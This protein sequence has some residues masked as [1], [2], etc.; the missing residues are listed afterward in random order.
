V[1]SKAPAV[2][3]VV[4]TVGLV[5]ALVTAGLSQ[6]VALRLVGL[7]RSTWHYRSKPRPRVTDPVPHT[8]RPS[9]S[10]LSTAEQDTIVAKLRAAFAQGWS[11]YHAYF[12]ALDAGDPV[13]SL[14]SWHRTARSHLSAQR[15]VK[16]TRNHRSCAMPSLVVDAPMQAWSWDIT[17]LKG[18]YR[19]VTYQFYVAIDVFSR[20]IVAWR[21]EAREDDDLARDMFDAAFTSHGA[22]PRIVHSDGG[23]AMTSN[24]LT[25]LFRELGIEVSRN[26]PRVS[27]DNPFSEALFKTAK[28]DPTYPTHFTDIEHARTWATTFVAWYNHDHHHAGLAGHTPAD[29]HHGTWREVH[30]RRVTAMHQLYALHPERFRNPP[31]LKTPM[32]QVA[33]NHPTTDDRLQTG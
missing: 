17:H 12:E 22:R 28:Y 25:G 15:P 6:R 16:R 10:W 19:R 23:S 5:T 4:V 8:A 2:D 31:V 11:V 27:N 26:R 33:I 24:T 21:L 20:M 18:P 7:S 30:D 14:S 1:D 32:A 29:V 3:V 9:S 13:A